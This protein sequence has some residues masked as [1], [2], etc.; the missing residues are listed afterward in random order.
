[1]STLTYTP[2]HRLARYGYVPFMLVGLN[3]TAIAMT[4]VGAPKYW[5][6]AVLAVAIAVSFLVER[7]IPYDSSWNH[8]RSDS[9]RDRIH[10]AVN[11]TLILASVAVEMQ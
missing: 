1:M 6:L 8:D 5:L 3:W 10:V 11:E 9:T 2:V 7:L 4:A